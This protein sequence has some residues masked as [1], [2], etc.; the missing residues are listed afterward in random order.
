MYHKQTITF[1]IELHTRLS[2]AA[3]ACGLS[4]NQYVIQRLCAKGNVVFVSLQELTQALVGLQQ[5]LVDDRHN[6]EELSRKEVFAT[7]RFCESF[8]V[9]TIKKLD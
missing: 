5:M 9:R 1:P 4:L 6:M 3:N 7:C 2:R 8:L